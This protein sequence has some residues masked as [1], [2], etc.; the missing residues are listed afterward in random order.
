MM[1]EVKFCNRQE[2]CPL[3]MK[4]IEE[5]VKMQT[6]LNVERDEWEAKRALMNSLFVTG[7]KLRAAQQKYF[8]TRRHE[9]LIESRVVESEFDKLLAILKRQP[10]HGLPVQQSL[11]NI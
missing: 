6:R 1:P 11:P 10:K 5:K 7:V 2:E 4:A 8:K 3:V 9:D